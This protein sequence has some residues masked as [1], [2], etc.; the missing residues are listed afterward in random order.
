[1][2]ISKPLFE[3]YDSACLSALSASNFEPY[4]QNQDE[5]AWALH[6]FSGL[7]LPPLVQSQCLDAT[8]EACN[9]YV[10]SPPFGSQ[11]AGG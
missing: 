4:S 7:S 2:F 1:M 3:V 10:C 5:D 11:G 6:A 9:V 8:G